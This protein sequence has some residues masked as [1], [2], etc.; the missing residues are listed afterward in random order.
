MHRALYVGI[1]LMPSL[2]DSQILKVALG[3][4]TLRYNRGRWTFHEV[5][6]QMCRGRGKL[7]EG[8]IVTRGGRRKRTD[9]ACPTCGGDGFS[10]PVK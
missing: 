3:D 4:A 2:T 6:C 7:R 9:V 1:Q 8:V 10:P 5:P